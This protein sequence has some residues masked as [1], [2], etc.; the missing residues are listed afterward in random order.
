MNV[1][2]MCEYMTRRGGERL[3]VHRLRDGCHGYCKIEDT[4]A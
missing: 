2:Y 4:I 3:R 1:T